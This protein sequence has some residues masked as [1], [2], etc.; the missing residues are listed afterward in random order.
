MGVNIVLNPDSSMPIYEQIVRSLKESLLK[1]ELLPGDMLPSIRSLAKDLGISVITTKRA[2]E[3]LEKEKL[4]YS[5]QGKGFFVCEFDKR[6]LEEEKLLILE[7]SLLQCVKEGKKLNL[8][9]QE[10]QEILEILW[11]GRDEDGETKM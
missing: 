10:M 11:K 1:K 9:F 5:K 6:I 2:Y 4:I 8:T 3:E 7:S